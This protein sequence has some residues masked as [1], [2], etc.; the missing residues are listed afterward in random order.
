[1]GFTKFNI[2]T[3]NS[4][5]CICM[6]YCA[7]VHPIFWVIV[8]HVNL[9]AKYVYLCL[10]IFKIHFSFVSRFYSLYRP[11]TARSRMLNIL[12]ISS[13]CLDVDLHIVSSS[14][15]GRLLSCFRRSLPCS[16]LILR[17]IVLFFLYHYLLH[18]LRA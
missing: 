1:M 16:F 9:T 18:V 4:A 10:N 17:D 7:L 12:T 8:W 11:S 13:R 14:L 6:L 3:F 2:E 15:C 5:V